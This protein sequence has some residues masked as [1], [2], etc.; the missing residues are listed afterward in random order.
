M[1][2]DY[3]FEKYFDDV[4]EFISKMFWVIEYYLRY[5]FDPG[6]YREIVTYNKLIEKKSRIIS[7][8]DEWRNEGIGKDI[9]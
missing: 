2:S 7:Q 4:Y 1:L 8:I 5:Y 3:I 6:F 9:D